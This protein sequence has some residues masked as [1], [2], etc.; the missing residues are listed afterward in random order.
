[1]FV[2]GVRE[3]EREKEVS[4]IRNTKS[5]RGRNAIHSVREIRV[6]IVRELCSRNEKRGARDAAHTDQRSTIRSSSRT[7]VN[8]GRITW[9]N[10]VR[11]VFFL[12]YSTKN[13]NCFVST[14][15]FIL[16]LSMILFDAWRCFLFDK[17][18]VLDRLIERGSEFR[19]KGKIFYWNR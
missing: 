18:L 9:N 1:M 19:S 11:W 15:I 10:G 17:K 3:R 4:G 8:H 2:S 13:K 14:S 12:E 16:F 7:F 6:A 5:A